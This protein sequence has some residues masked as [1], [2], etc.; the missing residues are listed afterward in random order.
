MRDPRR[1]EPRPKGKPAY[2]P[3][4]VEDLLEE[5]TTLAWGGQLGDQGSGTLDDPPG[6]GKSGPED[7]T[8]RGVGPSI[9]NYPPYTREPL[10]KGKKAGK[11]RR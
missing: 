9:K 2:K 4:L 5:V 11:L 1:S 10:A 3:T 6:T 7:P 8:G